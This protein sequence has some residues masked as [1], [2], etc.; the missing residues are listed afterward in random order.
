MCLPCKSD[1]KWLEPYRISPEK[2]TQC[3]RRRRR[4]SWSSVGIQTSTIRSADC[5]FQ[6]KPRIPPF[7]FWGGGCG[8]GVLIIGCER[9]ILNRKP[10]SVTPPPRARREMFVFTC[11]QCV[12]FIQRDAKDLDERN[13][14][15]NNQI[16][17][18]EWK[19]PTQLLGFL[20]VTDKQQLFQCW[21][22]LL[23]PTSVSDD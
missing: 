16:K 12:A 8:T 3:L 20:D 10:N 11:I 19:I 21:R 9:G 15:K 23:K 7:T 1:I 6:M 22:V 14:A 2:S 13:R 18:K 17:K 5:A 4:C